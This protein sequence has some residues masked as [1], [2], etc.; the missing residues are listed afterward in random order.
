MTREEHVLDQLQD[1]A[2]LLNE[3]VALGRHGTAYAWQVSEK[4]HA[5]ARSL[6]ALANECRT[7]ARGYW[8]MRLEYDEKGEPAR[9]WIGPGVQNRG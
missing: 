4:W 7:I 8:G 2:D 9:L 6:E 3:A 1:A 5:A